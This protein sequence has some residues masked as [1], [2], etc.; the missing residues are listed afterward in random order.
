MI[1]RGAALSQLPPAATTISPPTVQHDDKGD[2]CSYWNLRSPT[3]ARVLGPPPEGDTA[4]DI[5][6]DLYTYSNAGFGYD[7]DNIDTVGIQDLR[8]GAD[9][10]C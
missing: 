2:S 6:V 10:P 5:G 9:T 8:I 4:G 7:S 1:A 3:L